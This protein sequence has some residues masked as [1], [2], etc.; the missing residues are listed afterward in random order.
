LGYGA[1]QPSLQVWA[2]NR[3]PEHRMGAANGTFLSSMDL[4]FTLGSIL[5]SFIAESKS[6]AFMYRFSAV[7]VV[8]LLVVYGVSL[9]INSRQDNEYDLDEEEKAS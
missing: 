7:F 6:Y 1:V 5:L 9:F 2:V 3:S 4:A 8:I